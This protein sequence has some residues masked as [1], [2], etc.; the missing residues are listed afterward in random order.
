MM[1]YIK[2]SYMYIPSYFV[3]CSSLEMFCVMRVSEPS[4]HI[5]SAGIVILRVDVL[6]H[7]VPH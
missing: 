6:E 3:Q 4:L 5:A 1:G 7:S 2:C